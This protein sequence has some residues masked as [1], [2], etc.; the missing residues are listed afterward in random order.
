[1]S[2]NY[3]PLAKTAETLLAKFGQELTFTRTSK[4]AYD[5][6]TGATSDTT[7]TFT[8]NGVLFDYRDADSANQTVLAGDR[9]LVS[10]AHAYEVG[11]TVAVGSDVYRVV[12]ISTNQ[13][14]DTALVSDLQIR[15]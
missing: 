7:S 2:F 13:P 1:M 3:A 5:P 14:A 15:K 9:R 4:G 6:G 12:S 10:E 8:K 11:D